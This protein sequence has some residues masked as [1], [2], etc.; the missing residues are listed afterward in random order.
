[1]KLN[2][3]KILETKFES[4]I[5]GYSPT[6]VDQLLDIIIDDYEQMINKINTLTEK[7]NLLNKELKTKEKIIQKQ[8]EELFKFK[9]NKSVNSA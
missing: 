2:P 7:N 6:K 8:E 9:N 5:N 4:V 1:M 3:K